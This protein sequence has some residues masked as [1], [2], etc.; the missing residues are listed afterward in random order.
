M[1]LRRIE[2]MANVLRHILPRF[3]GRIEFIDRPGS[4]G[5]CYF[6]PRRKDDTIYISYLSYF[7]LSPLE[8]SRELKRTLLHEYRHLQQ[9]HM[10]AEYVGY[11]E[12]WGIYQALVERDGKNEN[13][14]EQDAEY[15]ASGKH[16][17]LTFVVEQVLESFN[18]I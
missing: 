8:C 4:W 18:I 7:D 10:L 12:A 5:C 2:N 13:A 15:Y 9:F 6:M 3:I 11:D 16:L 14:F 1:N 17:N